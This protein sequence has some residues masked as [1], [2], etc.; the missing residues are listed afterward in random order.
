[1]DLGDAMGDSDSD[2]TVD[3][4]TRQP[5][6]MDTPPPR[7]ASP[8][9]PQMEGYNPSDSFSD[10]SSNLL[11]SGFSSAP[12]DLA[13]GNVI[14][15]SSSL[16]NTSSSLLIPDASSGGGSRRTGS[17]LDSLLDQKLKQ[18]QQKKGYSKEQME[19]ESS[20]SSG[21]KGRGSGDKLDDSTEAVSDDDVIEQAQVDKEGS[22]YNSEEIMDFGEDEPLM[23]TS[24]DDYNDSSENTNDSTDN[25]SGKSSKSKESKQSDSKKTDKAGD[26]SKKAK[27]KKGE[28]SGVS[29]R[30]TRG[31]PTKQ[32]T[33]RG[34]TSKD[35]DTG[36]ESDDSW[37][38]G[39]AALAE[40]RPPSE[41]NSSEPEE[42]EEELIAL[43]AEL[44]AADEAAA[45]AKAEQDSY[46]E[47]DDEDEDDEEDEEEEYEFYEEEEFDDEDIEP[48]ESLIEGA[49][50]EGMEPGTSKDG[51]GAKA[52]GEDEPPAKK[53]KRVVKKRKKK[54]EQDDEE[55]DS[56]T[57]TAEK[58]KRRKK[59]DKKEKREKKEKEEKEAAEKEKGEKKKAN[60]R[61]N[62]R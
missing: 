14:D 3:M 26:L 8:S 50:V 52:D 42:T 51:D 35:G 2:T 23:L 10:P 60:E 15:F 58:K 22:D 37:D 57:G 45:K 44:D 39:W 41:Y 49:A 12:D 11:K 61:R 40:D 55:S 56:E 34:G 48:I 27:S 54:G 7:E 19:D 47:D 13:K 4:S 17:V 16:D 32:E 21:G 59:R 36:A 5:S 53:R 30:K 38:G 62:I 20:K 18:L 28:D 25:Q 46:D 1:M 6:G 31:K 33:G 24:D 43:K 9:L 29:S